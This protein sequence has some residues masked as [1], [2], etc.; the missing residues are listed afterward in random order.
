MTSSVIGGSI[1][2]FFFVVSLV[3]F[4]NTKIDLKREDYEKNY[5]EQLMTVGKELF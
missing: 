1:Y 2:V 3:I 5:H 4:L